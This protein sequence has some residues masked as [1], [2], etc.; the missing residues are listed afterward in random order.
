MSNPECVRQ[1]KGAGSAAGGVRTSQA[2]MR[3]LEDDLVEMQDLLAYVTTRLSDAQIAECPEIAEL[4]RAA[5]ALAVYLR[6]VKGAGSAVGGVRTSQARLRGLEDDLVEM[7]DLLAYVTTRLSDAQIA[8][9]VPRDCGAQTGGHRARG[10]P[11]P[12]QG[13]AGG[14]CKAL[15]FRKAGNGY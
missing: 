7:Q 14:A 12:S 11:A 5:I 9:R 13:C 1:V 8:R 3:G 6:Q 10:V 2:R 4:R 15:N